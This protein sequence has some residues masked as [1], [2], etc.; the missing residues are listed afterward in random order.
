VSNV[1][2]EQ[3]NISTVIDVYNTI[4]FTWYTAYNT[5]NNTNNIYLG[6]R[7]LHYLCSIEKTCSI[8]KIRQYSI[9][10]VKEIEAV[11]NTKYQD[12]SSIQVNDLSFNN[13]RT[14]SKLSY[15]GI[16][17]LVYNILEKIENLQSDSLFISLRKCSF[18]SKGMIIL[19]DETEQCESTILT[20]KILY[21]KYLNTWCKN[22]FTK[23]YDIT[24][25]KKS[26]D[27]VNKC[28]NISD[29]AGSCS[30]L[31]QEIQH[32]KY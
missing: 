3:P 9:Q 6:N 17:T 23:V 27:R 14:I 28:K 10:L 2:N 16:L 1:D 29:I 21:S 20:T 22:N 8:N 11:D 31:L 15:I 32:T 12:I 13:L 18:T 24:K 7:V 25:L 5:G 26:I 19:S 4:L 30:D